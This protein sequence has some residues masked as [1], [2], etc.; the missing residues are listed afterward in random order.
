MSDMDVVFLAKVEGLLRMTA[1]DGKKLPT[2]RQ[3]E[4]NKKLKAELVKWSDAMTA[5]DMV[6]LYSG[7]PA[8]YFDN[9]QRKPESE[10]YR[11]HA[12]ETLKEKFR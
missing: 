9:P 5:S 7:D 1:E 11:R 6:E 2:R 12:L 8:A 3:W 10:L 4:A